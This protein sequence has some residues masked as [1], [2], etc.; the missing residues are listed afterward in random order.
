MGHIGGLVA[1][2]AWLAGSLATVSVLPTSGGVSGVG[3]GKVTPTL[4]E[5]FGAVSW[6]HY[7][8]YVSSCS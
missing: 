6:I 5:L 1:S 2:E 4:G 3:L 8:E 7:V